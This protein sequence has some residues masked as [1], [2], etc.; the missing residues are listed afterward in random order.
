MTCS[1]NESIFSFPTSWMWWVPGGEPGKLQFPGRSFL[2]SV[3]LIV[4]LDKFKPGF[5]L[6][7]NKT[8]VQYYP[9]R[10]QTTRK[11][12]VVFIDLLDVRGK[13]KN[14]LYI[15]A[16]AHTP[17]PL[18]KK[19]TYMIP[20]GSENLG[21][22]L[23][24]KKKSVN[25]W[26]TLAKDIGEWMDGLLRT[27]D[28]GVDT[29]MVC[30]RTWHEAVH[31]KAIVTRAANGTIQQKRDEKNEKTKGLENFLEYY[32]LLTLATRGKLWQRNIS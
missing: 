24:C 28:P 19:N 22:S 10:R 14:Y 23:T 26:K 5:E 31:H 18:K 1:G 17:H 4:T 2:K 6:F 15:A 27:S 25:L 12:I 16:V 8:T 30:V 13:L 7:I 29:R 21:N 9:A 11:A 32:Q 3:H 20:Q